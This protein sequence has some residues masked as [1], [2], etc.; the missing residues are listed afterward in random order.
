MSASDIADAI[1]AATPITISGTAYEAVASGG[2]VTFTEAADPASGGAG[3]TDVT[4]GD[5]L[6]VT[7]V[8]VGLVVTQQGATTVPGSLATPATTSSFTVCFDPADTDASYTFNGET[9]PVLEDQ[10]GDAIA[11][12]FGNG[13]YDDWDVSYP[14]GAGANSVT[15]TAKTDGAV[16]IPD[17]SA[18]VGTNTVGEETLAETFNA[19]LDFLD[20]SDYLTSQHDA[21]SGPGPD[22]NDSNVLK[23]VTL[24]Y[25]EDSDLGGSGDGSTNAKVEAN[26]VAVVRMANDSTD[27][28]TFGSLSATDVAA[29]FNNDGS[30][31]GFGSDSSFGNLDAADF[32]VQDYT[33]TGTNPA[34][35]GDGKAIFK[36]ENPGNLGEYKVFELTWSGDAAS[37]SGTTVAAKEIGS[38]DY[39][40]SLNGLDDINLVGSDAYGELIY[41]GFAEYSMMGA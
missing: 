2:T 10:S 8:V 1:E 25:N 4:I 9:V 31:T 20:Y 12:A 14:G 7:G 40:T 15:F 11:E 41:N 6:D 27:G 28:E 3:P 38:Q 32:S 37:A 26:E 24:D 21:S 34:L 23:A 29:L 22:S 17:I 36:V 13:D 18:F 30:Y 33:K 5:F 35:I 16:A 39:G 19:G